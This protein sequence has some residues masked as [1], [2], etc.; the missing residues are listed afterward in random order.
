MC[1]RFSWLFISTVS[2][3]AS[4]HLSTLFIAVITAVSVV[5]LLLIIMAF[6]LGVLVGRK[7]STTFLASHQINEEDMPAFGETTAGMKPEKHDYEDIV[8]GPREVDTYTNDA[9]GL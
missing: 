7:I 4:V 9:Y 1:E 2:S 6:V 8:L 3:T 5:A